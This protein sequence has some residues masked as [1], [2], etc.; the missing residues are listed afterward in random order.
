MFDAR[1]SELLQEAPSLH[2]LDSS[3]LPQLLTHHYAELVSLRLQG[4]EIVENIVLS[5]QWPLKRIADVY[6][7]I[8]SIHDDTRLRKS[9]AFVSGTARLI[10]ARSE[11]LTT[12]I[13]EY[14]PL[15]RDKVESSVS[16]AILF[17]AAE[18]YADAFE[19]EKFILNPKGPKEIEILGL[20]LKDLVTGKLNYIL[21]RSSEWRSGLIEYGHIQDHA[22]RALSAIIVEGIELLACEIMSVSPP[23]E[24]SGKYKTSKEAFQ[25]VIKLASKK[26]DYQYISLQTTYAG[27]SHLASLLLLASDSLEYA[28]LTKIPPPVG[29]DDLFWGKWINWRANNTPFLWPNH[30]E[31]IDKQFYQIGYSS[32]LVLPTGAGK[33]TVSTLKIAATLAINK[34]V[35]FLVPTHALVEQVTEDLQEIFPEHKFGLSISDD[36]DALFVDESYFKDIEV[37]TP[38]RCLAMLSFNPESF[39]QV[40]LLVF[41]ECHLLSP[42]SGKIGRSLDGMLCVLTFHKVAPKAD[43]LFL[44]A[45]LKNGKEF[46]DWI[47]NLTQRPCVAIDLLWKPSRQAR[48]VVIYHEEEID[49]IKKQAFKTQNKIDIQAHKKAKSLRTR[50]SQKLKAIPYAIWGLK[51]NWLDHNSLAVTK[52]MNEP[53]Q[54]TGKL[55]TNPRKKI[56]IS[57]NANHVAAHIASK[58]TE[59]NLKTIV[60][61]NRKDDAVS[62][63]KKIAEMFED[64]IDFDLQ[65]SKLWDSLILELG[66][67]K[68]AIFDKE[69]ISAVPHHASML[70]IERILAER[71][72]RRE[73]GSSVIVATPTLA[74]GLNLPANFAILAGDKRTGDTQMR[75]NLETH[76][77]LNAAARAG[78]AG[79][80]A[81]GVVLLISEPI[82]TFSSDISITAELK[83]KL[84]SILPENDQCVTISDPLQVVLDRISEG[85][86]N[87]RDVKYVMNRLVS[88][89]LETEESTARE[90]FSESYGKFIAMKRH[91]E[92]AYE[93]KIEE[94][95]RKTQTLLESHYDKVDVKI[96]AQS[97]LS[98]SLLERLRLRLTKQKGNLPTSIKDWID[99]TF[100]WLIEDC[101]SCDEL[102]QNIY[103]SA[104]ISVGKS[105]PSQL[106]ESDLKTILRAMHGWIE[107]RPLNEIE[108]ILGGNPHGSKASEILCPRSRALTSTFIPRG[109]S[110]ILMIIA[111]MVEE[112]DLYSLQNE[113]DRTLVTSLSSAVRRGFD[114]VNKLEFSNNNKHI[115]GRVEV[116]KLY[117][118]K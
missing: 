56:W 34:K 70:R 38:E 86:L 45:M 112:L 82:M 9:S 75:E 110:Y 43:M 108:V 42:Q 23:K 8:A 55:T 48:G 52:I 68:H 76:E 109:F 103:K 72:F 106:Q 14:Y 77:L 39:S 107:G 11:E 1:T 118:D 12:D 74:Q 87:D 22:L 50:A 44:S 36:F 58:A 66:D 94:L 102:L 84:L 62:T 67:E 51:N 7:T 54:L 46:A 20:H 113:L 10:L 37:M 69:K 15:S 99:W 18:Q 117:T 115:R 71:L 6:E 21:D 64:T 79:H 101:E 26:T 29:I 93:Q 83:K 100:N 53:I 16:A 17:L 89:K 111:R 28:A 81:N 47:A 4:Q 104:L 114:T 32:V 91:D 88:L 5:E 95:W 31:A 49:A 25:D 30:R 2:N 90:F 3:L 33:T 60:F 13:E 78:R 65:E 97:G 92:E 80:L 98:L 96:A 24:L 40:G 73:N 57:P 41:D 59:A 85:E 63:S 27:P 19:A 116:H 35:I 105:S 61:V